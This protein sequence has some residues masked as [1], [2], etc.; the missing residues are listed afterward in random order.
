MLQLGL[1]PGESSFLG[2]VSVLAPTHGLLQRSALEDREMPSRSAAEVCSPS[3]LYN[4]LHFPSPSFFSCF[5][6]IL[7]RVSSFRKASPLDF[8]PGLQRIILLHTS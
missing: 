8:R 7:L 6:S 1:V 2:P 4:F 3:L 5:D